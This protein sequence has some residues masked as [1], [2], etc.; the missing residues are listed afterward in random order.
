MWFT[1]MVD[2]QDGFSTHFW[3]P[4]VGIST[5]NSVSLASWF[6]VLPLDALL[7]DSELELSYMREGKVLSPPLLASDGDRNGTNL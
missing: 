1:A 4:E 3:S 2:P 7:G 6:P 5:K